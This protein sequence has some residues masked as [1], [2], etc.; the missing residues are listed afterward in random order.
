[1]SKAG[2]T[3]DNPITGERVVVRVGTEESEDQLLEVDTYVRPG[4]AVTGEHIH[5][6]IEES[7][8]V[9]SG[10]VGF[11][12]NGRESIAE[13]DRP[14]RVPAGVAHDWW[15]AGEE[16]AHIIVEIRPG[17]RFEKMARN[18][19]GL[20]Q[21]GKTNSKGMPNLLQAAIFAREF[22]DV[23][24]FTKPPLVVQRL[25]FGAPAAIAW[26]LGYRGSYPSTAAVEEP[27]H[28]PRQ[29]WWRGRSRWQPRSCWHTY[30]CAQGLVAH[31]PFGDRACSPGCLEGLS[32]E[33]L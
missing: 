18:L 24:Y 6:A 25:L 30:S 33:S 21:D 3:I 19:F 29:G 1:M 27:A 32:P 5:P 26:S 9:V 31:R 20:A 28:R 23:L 12:L 16:E 10:R 2:D 17:E 4:G 14:L 13:L 8:T 15:N 7:F 22:S 11:R